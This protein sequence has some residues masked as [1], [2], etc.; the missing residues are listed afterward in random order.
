MDNV[1]HDKRGYRKINVCSSDDD[2]DT[3]ECQSDLKKIEK[4]CSR[5][6]KNVK[7]LFLSLIVK[8]IIKNFGTYYNKT[9]Q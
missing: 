7:I 9:L 5:C 4:N 8:V 3:H 1:T 6:F 2:Y